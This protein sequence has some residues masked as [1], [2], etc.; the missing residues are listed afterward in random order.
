[1]NEI[2]PSDID[3]KDLIEY[4]KDRKGHDFR[5]AINSKKVTELGWETK[6]EFE[7]GLKETIDYYINYYNNVGL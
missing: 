5:Y 6:Y 4:V 2:L 3:Y 7:D 1:M